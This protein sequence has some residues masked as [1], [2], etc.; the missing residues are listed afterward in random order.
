MLDTDHPLAIDEQAVGDST[1]AV[2]LGYSTI[3]IQ[4]N[5]ECQVPFL[6]EGLHNCSPFADIYRQQ[7]ETLIEV[8]FVS[9]LQ[10]GPLCTTV[11]SPG[12]PEIEQDHF[13]LQ[14]AQ[15]PLF[16]V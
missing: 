1:H 6:G 10:S 12:G 13:A 14:F 8:S 15:R 2:N 5:G 4:Q 11:W 7:D 3:S 16:T 9:G